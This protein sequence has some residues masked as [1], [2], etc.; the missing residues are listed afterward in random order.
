MRP[1]IFI[2]SSKEGLNIAEQIKAYFSKDFDC[3]L[4]SDDI[5]K[6]N[7]NYLETLMKEASLFDFGFMVCTNDDWTKSRDVEQG[8]PRDNVIFEYGLFLGRLGR[9]R[10]YIIHDKNI[11]L[12]SDL[13]GI[14]LASFE[15]KDGV[16]TSYDRPF[17]ALLE[18]LHNEIKGK[19]EIGLLGM[20][21]STVL[22]IGYFENF[23]KPVCEYLISHNPINVDGEDLYC[24]KFRVVIPNDLDA[25]IKKRALI[26]HRKQSFKELQIPTESRSY[27]LYVSVEKE[28]SQALLSDMPTTLNGIDKAIDM[29]LRK[30]H[31]GKTQEQQLL[32]DR[33]LRNFA[34]VLSKLVE[35]DAFCK[36]LI[37]VETE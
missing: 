37:V 4:W 25:D 31:I 36:E 9:D 32:E 24:S 1:R 27:P 33:E 28:G 23:I 22:A 17:D 20:L 3:N 2:G 34:M 6:Y 12:P 13:H 30:G 16:L 19:I 14:T 7:D 15:V 11:K 21:P 35:N 18:R 26:Y 8:S 10:A 5:F 29:Y